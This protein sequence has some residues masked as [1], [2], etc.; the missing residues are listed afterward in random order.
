MRLTLW[1]SALALLVATGASAASVNPLAGGLSGGTG[2][3]FNPNTQQLFITEQNSGELSRFDVATNTL[4]TVH[5]GLFYPVSV[6]LLDNTYAYVT[7]RDGR[8]YKCALN[9]N[10]HSELLTGLGL[11][12]QIAIDSPSATA[13]VTNANTGNLWKVSLWGASKTLVTTGLTRAW[14]VAMSA[15]AQTAYITDGSRLMRFNLATQALTEVATGID[16]ITTLEWADDARSALYVVDT[17]TSRVRRVDL[18]TSPATVSHVAY[19]P[20]TA[21]AVS[22]GSNPNVVYAVSNGSLNQILLASSNA[23]V[24][25]RVGHIPSTQIDAITGRATTDPAY[26]FY[27]KNASFGG[28]PHLFLNYPNLRNLSV[29]SYRV[30]VD[31][32]AMAERASWNNYKWNGSTF[33]LTPVA[34][35]ANGFYAVPSAADTWAIPDLG[36]ILDTLKLSTGRHLITVKTYDAAKNLLATQGQVMLQ[37]DNSGPTMHIDEISHDGSPVD[38]CALITSGS[39]TLDFTFTASDAQGHLFN[40][41]LTDSWGHGKSA[42]ITSDQYHGVH[43]S[44]STWSGVSGA[45]VSYTLSCAQCAHAFTLSGYSN[46]TNGFGYIQQASDS[47][48]IAVYLPGGVC[49]P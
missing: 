26:F 39:A 5:T 44:V 30:F 1:A 29:A 13:Y 16:G 18:S 24:I 31:N 32:N 19:L 38:A 23:P 41:A 47:E 9:A 12:W 17:A 21:N 11:P 22:R 8:L 2:S 33:V 25:T 35:D 15:D 6:A 20:A 43:D 14:G 36:F 27:V 40:Y 7:S 48:H 28:S 49:A 10:T 42:V 4:A 37:V 3:A 34:P 45:T 46:T